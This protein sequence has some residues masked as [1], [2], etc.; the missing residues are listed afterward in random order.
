MVALIPGRQQ[1]DGHSH[2]VEKYSKFAYSSKFG[3]SIMRSNLT[4]AECA[5]DSTPVFEVYGYFFVK[6]VIEPQ[7]TVSEEKLVFFWTPIKGIHVRTTIKPT[8]TGH[9]RTHEIT[10]DVDCKAYDCG[11]ALSSDDRQPFCTAEEGGS[12]Y[13]RTRTATAE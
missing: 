1:A 4:L 12:S 11:F 9:V 7:F 2:T 6:D 3:F 13:W 8:K 10:S 5:P